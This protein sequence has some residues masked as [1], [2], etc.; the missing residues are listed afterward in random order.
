MG[1]NPDRGNEHQPIEYR[2]PEDGNHPHRGA[3]VEMHAPKPERPDSANQG[4]RDVEHDDERVAHPA[5]AGVK[6]AA[7]ESRRVAPS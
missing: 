6:Q 7:S 3:P 4:E 2:D 5:E 1:R